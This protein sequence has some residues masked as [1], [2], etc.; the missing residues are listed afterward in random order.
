MN[1]PTLNGNT[2]NGVGVRAV[3]RKGID[4]SITYAL[5]VMTTRANGKTELRV[6]ADTLK[7]SRALEEVLDKFT[8][9]TYTHERALLLCEEFA[10]QFGVEMLER[11]RGELAEYRAEIA[12]REAE[13]KEGDEE[14][15]DEEKG[16]KDNAKTAR[17]RKTLTEKISAILNKES[18][19]MVKCEALV[20]CLAVYNA[21]AAAAARNVLAAVAVKEAEELADK[22]RRDAEDARK[23][24]ENAAK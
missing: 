4:Q 18:G 7:G 19:A 2:I 13:A 16:G 9:K 23:M 5:A 11:E 3:T 10:K 6:L 17:P 1:R 20:S 14:K 12:K 15:G 24:A 22:A 21:A 8:A